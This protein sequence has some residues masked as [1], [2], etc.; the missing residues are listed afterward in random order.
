MRVVVVLAMGALTSAC[1]QPLYGIHP[2]GGEDTVRDKLGS[3]D[4]PEIKA[5]NGTPEARLA[6]GMQGLA[7]S[8]AKRINKLRGK[9][10]KVFAHR[11][12]A[13]PLRS[14][15]QARN[16]IAYVLNNWRHHR[17]DRGRAELVDPYATGHAFFGWTEPVHWYRDWE[18]IPVAAPETWLRRRMPAVSIS[19]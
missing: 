13:T 3:I 16:A 15:T 14:P 11:Y 4:I 19:R 1:F 6:V 9:D 7:I 8:I 10:G 5:S 17:E 18:P 12:H 2:V